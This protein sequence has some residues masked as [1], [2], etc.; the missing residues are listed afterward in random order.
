[1]YQFQIVS[2]LVDGPLMDK[3]VL[4]DFPLLIKNIL[5]SGN[6]ILPTLKTVEGCIDEEARPLTSTITPMMALMNLLLLV[7]L[8]LKYLT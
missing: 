5:V 1:M 2:L 6:C 7:R 8:G 4:V 3:I